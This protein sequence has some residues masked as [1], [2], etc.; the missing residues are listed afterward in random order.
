MLKKYCLIAA[1]AVFL[2]GCE[3][4]YRPEL[5][6]PAELEQKDAENA[7]KMSQI[8][9]IKHE[10]VLILDLQ[11][12]E[13]ALQY[14]EYFADSA[15]MLGFSAVA[16]PFADKTEADVE[17]DRGKEMMDFVMLL[18]SKSLKT[19]YLLRESFFVNRRR[20][21]RFLWGN[22]N[23][24]KDTLLQ[25]R[26]FWKNLPES[27]EMPTVVVALEMNRWND[28]NVNRPSGLLFT[29]RKE[30]DKKGDSNDRMFLK[31]MQFFDECRKIL[32]LE[33]LIL[34]ED[35]EVAFAGSK[36]SL[37]GGRVSELLRKCDALAI[38]FE[39]RTDN[40][41]I[42]Q[43][44]QMLKD[45]EEKGSVFVLVSPG[46]KSIDSYSK[47]LKSLENWQKNS[48]KYPGSAGIWIQNWNKLNRIWRKAE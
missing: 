20:G 39:A 14:P 43:R 24:Y 17:N 16:V 46:N 30:K 45:A 25:L 11:E 31:S 13:F 15:K 38:D 6:R 19:I 48:V 18:N 32:E 22:G 41:V 9:G 4:V 34:L 42:N 40:D 3:S 35:E 27:A 5:P 8:L 33:Q 37:T 36:G 2:C 21:N 23:P 44:L 1:A 7:A 47:W 26:E 10:R 29:W 12:L 28:R